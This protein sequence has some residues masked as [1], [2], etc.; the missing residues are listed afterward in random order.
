M[1]DPSSPMPNVGDM[2]EYSIGE[3]PDT[4]HKGKKIAVDINTMGFGSRENEILLKNIVRS[5]KVH[6][7]PT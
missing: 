7:A 2:L 5:Q 6:A 4:R 3:N 1:R